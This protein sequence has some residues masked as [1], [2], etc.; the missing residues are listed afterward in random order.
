LAR[1]SLF[2]GY[3]SY[4]IGARGKLS[5]LLIIFNF[6]L[7]YQLV[8]KQKLSMFLVAGTILGCLFLLSM[9][10]RMYVFQ[11]FVVLLVFKTS[12]SQARWKTGKLLIFIFSGLLIG[13]A[14]G[15][16]RMGSSL[17][18]EKAAYS[19]FAEPTFTWFSTIS[20]L[21]SNEVP[22]LSFP[23]NFI[24]SFLNLVP[25][26][27]FSFKP[28][29]VSTASMVNDYQNPLGADSVWSTF[30]INFGSLGSC[31]FLC[32]TGFILNYL[33]HLSAQ[34]RFMAVYYIMV[35]GMLP[36]QFFRDGFYILNKQLFFNFLLL[37]AIL[38][39]VTN[40]VLFGIRRISNISSSQTLPSVAD[41]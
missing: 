8:S 26:T 33:R 4:D 12:F 23:S 9:G 39:G 29:I 20:Y 37:P 21:S 38:L 27:F 11:T 5:T 40:L 36:F 17:G 22:L 31:I 6:F 1:N 13:A 24:T 18:V 19:F 16:W 28:Y 32:V 7:L 35:C 3:G 25:N 30:V 2:G 15:L 10:G 41:E 34:S 14:F